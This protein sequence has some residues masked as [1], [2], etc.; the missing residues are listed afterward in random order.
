MTQ[1][2]QNV[3]DTA[4]MVAGFRA[5]ENERPNPLFRDPLAAKLAGDHD[6]NILATM[7]KAFM[8]AWSVVIRT[9][10]IDNL[11]N[12]AFAEGVDTILN[13]GAGLNTRPYRMALPK[14]L[15]WVEVDY[16]HVIALKEERLAGEEPYCRL[17]RIKL[18]LTDRAARRQFLADMSAEATKV[19]VLTEGVA[20]CLTETDV[21]ELAD[22]LKAA[23]KVR[24]WIVDYYS[25]EAIRYGE[26]MRARFMRNAPF[27]FTPQDW[28]D[29]F[30][31]HGW[32]PREVRYLF[33]EARRLGRPVPLPWFLRL[34][35]GIVRFLVSPARRE[36]MNRFAAYVMLEPR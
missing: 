4:F 11:I 18:D 12:Q 13:L 16:P 6:K 34:W 25:P 10:I 7:P 8:G 27:R 26:K 32:R 30:A 2:I 17:K 36:R 14:T 3:S 5:A 21:A 9:V 35:I 15:R 23:E 24:Y 1:V 31:S 22:D 28:F 29:F 19:L 33:D 20:P